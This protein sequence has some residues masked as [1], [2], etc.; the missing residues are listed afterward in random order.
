[1]K[2][3]CIA[4]IL[5]GLVTT[6][7]S[8]GTVSPSA[9][10]PSHPAA[11]A[12]PTAAPSASPRSPLEGTWTTRVITCAEMMAAVREA[13]LTDAQITASGW[14]CPAEAGRELI[15]F[16]AGHLVSFNH[17]G[18]VG[19]NGR[20]RI[21]DDETFEAG[22]NGTYYIT[23]HYALDGDK[24]TIEVIKDDYPATGIALLGDQVAQIAGY[25][26]APY[27]RQH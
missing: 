21:I 13:G 3:I 9:M 18:S 27:T 7:C 23:Y 10:R 11:S 1:M 19:W 4:I 5:I 25:N 24:L 15:R 14:T 17:D 20:Y 2:A 26:T 22:D 12:S 8:G 6:A 16:A